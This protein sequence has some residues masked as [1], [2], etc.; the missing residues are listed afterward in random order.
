MDAH[1]GEPGRPDARG[2]TLRV[3]LLGGLDM[4]LGEERVPPLDSAR[5]ESLLAYLLVHR[6]APQPRQRLAFLLWPESTEPQARTNLRQVLHNLRRALPDADR[7]IDVGPRTLQWREQAPLWLDVAIFEEAVAD[8]RLREAVDAYTGDLLEGSYDEWLVEE[9]ERLAHLHASALEGLAHELEDAGRLAEAIVC[10][11]HLQRTDALREETYR[12]LMRLHGA[13]G[14]GARALRVYHECATTLQREL[15]TAPSAATHA[16]YETVLRGTAEPASPEPGPASPAVAPLVGRLAQR[17]QLAALWRA[18]DQGAAQL[19][20]VTGEPGVGKTRLVDEL[21]SWCAHNGAPNAEARA[22]PAEGAMAYGMVVAW[23]RS[24]PIAA[25]LPRLD[26]MHLTELARLLPDLL[27]QIPGLPAPEPLPESEHRQRLFDAVARAILPTGAPLLLVADDL[28]WCDAQ[29]LQFLHYLLRAEPGARLL[30]AATARREDMDARHPASELVAAL[31][32][33]GRSTEIALERLTREQT[34]LLATRIAGSPLGESEAARLYADSEGNPLFVVEAFRADP[35]GVTRPGAG[36]SSKVQAVLDARLVQ[37][38]A[39]ADEL[40]GVAATIG[41]EFTAPLLAEAGGMDEQLFVQALDELWRRGLV[42]AHGPNAYDFSHG[43]IREAA[44]AALSPV[45]ARHHHLRVAQ[46]LER[47]QADLE[48]V[49]AQLAAHY[50]GAGAASEA[51]AW[52]VRTANAAQRLHAHDDAVQA[53]ERALALT[54]ALPAGRERSA[55]QLELLT[56]LPAPLIAIEDYLSERLARVLERALALARELGSEPGAPIVWSLALASLT[57][58]DFAD[59]LAA[60]EQLRVRA[61]REEDEILWVE[62]GYI[63]GVSSYWLGRLDTARVHFE[64]A[65]G[66][67]RPESRNAHVLRYGQDAELFCLLRLA[68]T[69]W[70]LGRLGEADRRRDEALALADSSAHPYSRAALMVWS[71]ILAL[72]QRDEQRLREHAAALEVAADAH[73]PRQIQFALEAF[74]GYVDVLDGRSEQG[75]A[76]IRRALDEIT[77]GGA[78]A[79]GTPGILAH[80]LLSACSE[81]GAFETG[82]AV[83]DAALG[84]GRGAELWEAEMRRLRAHFLAATGGPSAEIEAELRRAIAVAEVQGARTF[85]LRARDSL[86]VLCGERS[87]ERS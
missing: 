29:S 69:L 16:V 54:E 87:A 4:R 2:P 26:R 79:P 15:G 57:R 20:L 44:Y 1:T 56:A 53:L 70:L 68:H 8:G 24:E 72:D 62:S 28:Q 3:R 10:A 37:L 78:P 32:G 21:R 13:S 48:P 34:S 51:I 9:R 17:S 5:A 71:A 85:E 61:E 74:G 18:A 67:S 55:L 6:D 22:Y 52:Y 63:L 43:K 45:Q 64:A 39:P 40:I 36:V 23:L 38:S 81:A 30:V 11:A 66:R 31:Q 83:A 65:V 75:I 7:L 35:D 73:T 60:G 77:S 76:R 58:G 86:V 47:G 46:A 42:R 84:T 19:A 49:S 33:L 12:M 41:R 59:A 50:D 27:S 82:L 14:D 25:R 80:I